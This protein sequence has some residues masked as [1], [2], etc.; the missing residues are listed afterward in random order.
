MLESAKP[1]R[2]AITPVV[3][4]RLQIPSRIQPPQMEVQSLCGSL[5]QPGSQPESRWAG[6]E[7]E[8]WEQLSQGHRALQVPGGALWP[9]PATPSTLGMDGQGGGCQDGS[10]VAKDN[11]SFMEILSTARSMQSWLLCTSRDTERPRTGKDA[12]TSL[13]PSGLLPT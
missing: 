8:G 4:I 3:W 11:T 13:P 9:H 5:I 2:S 1:G 6:D 7:W 10:Q 12:W